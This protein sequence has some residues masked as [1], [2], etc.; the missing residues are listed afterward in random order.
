M[1]NN[2]FTAF[3]NREV[4]DLIIYDF[5]TQKPR[6]SFKYANTNT[7]ELTGE[8]VF[9][10]GGKGHPKRVTFNGE[11]GGTF[12]FETQMQTMEL[13]S[14][15]SGGEITG[16]ATFVK[17]E[18]VTAE[19]T[20]SLTVSGTPVQNSVFVYEENDDCGNAL[21]EVTV[22][23]SAITTTG[24]TS[25]NDYIVYY[26]DELEG[27]QKISIKSTTFPRACTIY[28]ETFEKTE[29]DEILPYKM[30]VYKASPQ[31]NITLSNSNNGDP[32]TLTVT[33]D[34]LADG[35]NNLIDMILEDEDA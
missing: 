18:V 34:L 9:A 13:H 8:A 3:A 11:K 22:S 10:Y 35:N 14:L 21:E 28:A 17:R 26:M 6:M 29:D 16:S 32:A 4:C 33:F 24:L 23:G 25:G 27:V 1:S 19:S 7:T 2:K 15:I 12:S 20:T 31:T 5:K 30:I